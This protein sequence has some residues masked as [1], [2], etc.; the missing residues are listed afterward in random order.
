MGGVQH[1]GPDT[2]S[3][4]ERQRKGV[5]P[6]ENS[7]DDNLAR[8][9]TKATG[10][11]KRKTEKTAVRDDQWLSSYWNRKRNEQLVFKK[12]ERKET[13]LAEAEGHTCK[14]P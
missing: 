2:L 3:G 7:H 13:L 6:A 11:Q 9:A 8:K 5:A 14:I 1:F 10:R 12:T 4:K